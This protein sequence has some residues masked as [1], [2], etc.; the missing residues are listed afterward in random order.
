MVF[1]LSEERT[2]GGSGLEHRSNV[3]VLTHS[4]DPLTNASYIVCRGSGQWGVFDLSEERTDGG[5]RL[6]HRFNVEVLIHPPDPLTNASY[7]G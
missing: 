3:E 5:S 4:P 6:E 2:E 1:D 7:I